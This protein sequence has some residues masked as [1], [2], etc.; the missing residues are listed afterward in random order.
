L[1]LLLK[2]PAAREHGQELRLVL[3]DRPCAAELHEGAERVAAR[4]RPER[5][6]HLVDEIRPR[7]S[8]VVLLQAVVPVLGSAFHVEG[9]EPH[10]LVV[11]RAIGA[12][13][14]LRLVKPCDRIGAAVVARK[15]ELV[16]PVLAWGWWGR[17]AMLRVLAT[18][19]AAGG[20]VVRLQPVDGHVRRLWSPLIVVTSFLMEERSARMASRVVLS[21]SPMTGERIERS[22]IPD[23]RAS[24]LVELY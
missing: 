17:G 4:R 6:L 15:P 9:G 24:N 5:P 20:V 10:A 19:G 2:R 16:L 3:L 12:E 11:R 13:K 14:L 21:S 8:A 7:W 1:V 22:L 18:V 23:D